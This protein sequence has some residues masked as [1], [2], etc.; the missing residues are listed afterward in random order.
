MS[1]VV[2]FPM[3]FSSPSSGVAL[4]PSVRL[5]SLPYLGLEPRSLESR[6]RGQGVQLRDVDERHLFEQRHKRLRKIE[7]KRERE[8]EK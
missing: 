3:V 2:I 7:K 6:A 1:K 4:C 5:F 8:R